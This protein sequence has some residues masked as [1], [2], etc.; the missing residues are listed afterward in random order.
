MK[1]LSSAKLA[2]MLIRSSCWQLFALGPLKLKEHDQ[3]SHTTQETGTLGISFIRE[4]H[5]GG[6]SNLGFAIDLESAIL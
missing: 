6:D 5:E 3:F 4:L 2:G 1:P